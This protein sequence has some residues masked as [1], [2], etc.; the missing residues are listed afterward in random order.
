MNIKR[1]RFKAHWAAGLGVALLLLLFGRWAVAAQAPENRVLRVAFPDLTGISEI[2]QYGKHK[3]LLVDYLNEIAKYT[4]WEYEYVTV[5]NEDLISNF[6]DGQYDLMGGT[7]YS[8]GFEKYFAYPEYNT[9]R[10]R[11]VLLCRREDDSLQSNDLTSLNGKTIGV[12]E[13]ATDKIRY[14]N[15]YLASNDLE[16]RIRYYTQ[17][18]MQD[19]GNLYRQLRDGEVDMLLGN[20]LEIGGEFRMVTSFQAQPYYI[21]TTLENTEVLAGLNMALQ[22]ILE[23]TPRFAEEVYNTHFPD[24][25]LIDIQLNEK[26]LHYIREKGTLIVAVPE[27]WHPFYCMA[28]PSDHHEGLLPDLFKE[29]TSFTGLGFSYMYADSYEEAIH[30]LQEGQVDL[31]GVYLGGDAE[32]FSDGFSLSQKYV[33]LNNLVLK[34]KAVSYPSPELICGILVGC[35][36]PANFEAAEVR[37]YGTVAELVE[38]VDNGRVD[39]IYGVSAMLEQEMQR[40]RYLNVV[41]MTQ[42]SDNTGVAFAIARP[43]TPELLTILNKAIGNISEK[44]RNKLLNKNLVSV[45]YNKLSLK[46]LMYANPVAFIMIFG[47]ALLLVMSVVLLV[48]RNRMKNSLMQGRLEASEAKSRAKSEFLS[49]MSHEI[50][51]PMNAIVGLTDLAC[52]EQDVSPEIVEKLKKIR[53]SSQYLLSLINDILDMARIENE[54]MVLVQESFS[55]TGMIDALQ[56][57]IRI[58]AEQKGLQLQVSCQIRHDWLV[59][60][61]IRL[62]QILMNLLSNAIKFTPD[63]GIVT[64]RV[65]ETAADEKEVEYRFAVEDTGVGISQENQ[66]K[67]FAAFEQLR[68]SPSRSAGTGLGLAIS[69]SIA[70]LMGGDLQVKSEPGKG[71]EFYMALRFPLGTPVVTDLEPESEKQSRSLE[72][73][74]IIL[75]EDNDLNAEIA[76]ELLATQGIRVSRV[77]D[78]QKAVD[79]FASSQTG[80]FQVILMDIRMPVKDGYEAAREIRSSGRADAN[81]P[82][83]AMTA[84]SFRE[85]EEEARAAGMN[86]FVPKPVNPVQLFSVVRDAL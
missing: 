57:M 12:Y 5:D 9:G 65:K 27:S 62:E 3:G 46:E 72:G 51:T 45:G 32:A 4:G 1:H 52:M 37:T 36:L 80:E 39:Y 48:V 13:R 63:G 31:L 16:C 55:L 29:I 53:Y 24:V 61:T 17:E 49:Q 2:D 84:N 8:S 19:N 30:M 78:G 23:S 86:G 76:Q 22:Y 35:T 59:G 44:E 20:D 28:D 64:L 6:L 77:A 21:V 25:K 58:Q 67:I 18:D 74:R 26:E 60:D 56:G 82:I 40:R 41:P 83:I 79:L 10:S 68:P 70:S 50:R 66:E 54:K 47:V 85:D 34:N 69:R 73:V 33:N 7:F 11:A 43:V 71:S 38:A 75:A 15:E 81:I 14:L 42:E